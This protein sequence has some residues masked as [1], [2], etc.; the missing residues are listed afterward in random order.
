M[1]ISSRELWA[2]ALEVQR[3]HGDDAGTFVAERIAALAKDGD[4][5]GIAAW[6]NIGLKIMA[7]SSQGEAL[8]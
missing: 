2:C 8:Q 7:L 6:Q 1:T 5:E 4:L 3:Q